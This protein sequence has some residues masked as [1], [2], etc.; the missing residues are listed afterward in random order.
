MTSSG[1][2]DWRFGD[3]VV[4]GALHRVLVG[5]V[6]HDL[7]PKSFRLLQFLIEHRDHVVTK[8][9]ILAAVWHG[10]VVS[11]NALSRAIAQVRKVIGD[12]SKQPH[13]VQTIPRVGYRFIA[14]VE[15]GAPT[16]GSDHGDHG[17][18]AAAA[19]VGARARRAS[20]SLADEPS[21]A[22]LPF[23]NLSA[24]RE[25]EFFADGLA[26]EILNVLARV[27][28]LKVIARTSSFTFRGKEQD[29][30]SIASALG[31]RHVLEG[32]VRR[33][34]TR[35]RVTTQLI[36]ARDGRHVW[37]ERYDRDVTDV[38]A[39]QDEISEAVCAALR[40]R[41]GPRVRP[42]DLEAY[43]L[44]LKGRHYLLQLSQEG[45][46]KARACF[47]QALAIDP[48][49]AAAHSALAEHHHTVYVMGVAP[50]AV[51]VPLVR[52]AAERALA[53]EPGHAEAH[54]LL[55][56]LANT[57]DYQWDLAETLHRQALAVTP[58]TSII[59]YRFVQWHLLPLGR[60]GEAEAQLRAA[61]LT[62]PLNMALQHG[63]S[64]CLLFAGRHEEALAHCQDMVA[65]DDSHANRLLLGWAQ[66]RAG[67]LD[68]AVSSLTQVVERMPWWTLAIGWLAAFSHLAGDRA[69]AE[70][71]GRSLPPCR[72]AATYHAA[73][74]HVDEMFEGLEVAWRQRDAFLPG[75]T[76]Q[77]VFEP[78][79]GEPRFQDL[80]A[81]MN[82]AV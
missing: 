72:D 56:A 53:I 10:T 40:V 67:D 61:L 62:D 57:V 70:A 39:I 74:G 46:A 9:E 29:V 6:A 77:V 30:S 50:A 23:A 36:D 45:M 52:A 63:L 51:Q 21:I 42:V 17:A 80:L 26:E 12:D 34:G 58:V 13:F 31:V 37:S 66:F 81:R 59:W 35:I 47:E 64:Q 27:P 14:E 43:Q 1:P 44:H 7:E 22:V 48:A 65:L 76:R 49:F 79:F 68:S 60:A 55:A 73:A 38:F 18:A 8:D 4:D 19:P 2:R 16:L 28:D 32:S 82:L 41:L 5:G 11:D 15:P 20:D 54:S 25:N 24:D 69:R 33:A 78:Y 71:L 75:I 3:V